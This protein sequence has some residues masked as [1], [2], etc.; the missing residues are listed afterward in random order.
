MSWVIT[1]ILLAVA[2]Y[3]LLNALRGKNQHDLQNQQ[4]SIADA[5]TQDV[6]QPSDTSSSDAFQHAGG[7][8]SGTTD[9]TASN[10]GGTASA[11]GSRVAN[12]AAAVAGTA[13]VTAAAA[14][15]S[16]REHTLK[17]VS[18][19]GIG[20]IQEMLKILNLSDS[21]SSRLA[22]DKDQ[23]AALKSGNSSLQDAELSTIAD[24]LRWMLR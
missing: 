2:A 18:G 9:N 4:A 22:I 13:G 14:I 6:A 15:A 8:P 21:D 11:A 16:A 24:K 3:F 19:S 1:L 7:M 5:D 17:A 23:F 12:G 10:A 20:D